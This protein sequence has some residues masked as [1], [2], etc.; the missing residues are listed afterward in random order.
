MGTPTAGPCRAGIAY[1]MLGQV[2]AAVIPWLASDIGR[3]RTRTCSRSASPMQLGEPR[4]WMTSGKRTSAPSDHFT[5][6][7][8]L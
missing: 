5:A 4:R 1:L 8:S 7:P 2:Y 3:V 6:F